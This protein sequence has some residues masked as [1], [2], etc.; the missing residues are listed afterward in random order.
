MLD[1]LG[2][3][4]SARQDLNADPLGSRGKSVFAPEKTSFRS[5]CYTHTERQREGLFS[6]FLSFLLLLCIEGH[7]QHGCQSLL[8]EKTRWRGK[9]AASL[10][11]I[12]LAWL[13]E[14][15]CCFPHTYYVYVVWITYNQSIRRQIDWK[16]IPRRK[17]ER[18]KK[19]LESLSICLANFISV[20]DKK[21]CSF[22]MKRKS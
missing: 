2:E 12:D 6:F 9:T 10:S 16:R 3:T 19:T 8:V 20:T 15:M 1:R 18:K 21:N 13:D 5:S 14:G 11:D 4:K 7:R 17:N 22:D